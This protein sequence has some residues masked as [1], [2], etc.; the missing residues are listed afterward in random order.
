MAE[1]NSRGEKSKNKEQSILTRMNKNVAIYATDSQKAK[2]N[3][4]LEQ[5]ESVSNPETRKFIINKM[6]SLETTIIQG[7]ITWLKSAYYSIFLEDIKYS[8]SNDAAFWKG[9][10]EKAIQN[11]DVVNLLQAIIKLDNLIIRTAGQS[12]NRKLA[13][14]KK[15]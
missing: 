13:D 8:D 14:L 5:L 3:E 10:A 7:N 11:N 1:R 2:Y 9:E 4:L 15:I 6:N 12:V